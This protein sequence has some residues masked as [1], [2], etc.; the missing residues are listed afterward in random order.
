MDPKNLVIVTPSYGAID[1]E[2][3]EACRAL[4]GVPMICSVGSTPLKEYAVITLPF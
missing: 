1:P 3:L 2:H 4:R